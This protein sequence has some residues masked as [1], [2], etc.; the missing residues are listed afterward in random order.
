[1]VSDPVL[2]RSEEACHTHEPRD[3]FTGIT[4]PPV[5]F[6]LPSPTSREFRI[7]RRID[8]G[9]DTLVG[10][11]LLTNVVDWQAFTNDAL[12]VNPC[13]VCYFIQTLDEHG[14]PSPKT[15]V[16]CFNIA[17]RVDLPTPVLARV[18]P[19]GDLAHP[20]MKLTWF[21]PPYGVERFEVW[22][23]D[24]S[25]APDLSTNFSDYLTYSNYSV[26]S[27]SFTNKGHLTNMPFYV[28]RTPRVGPGFGYGALF[29]VPVNITLG[30]TYAF[31]VKAMAADDS[32]VLPSNAEMALWAE[33]NKVEEVPW[34]ARPLVETNGNFNVDARFLSPTNG[35]SYLDSVYY[36][37]AVLIGRADLAGREIFSANEKLIRIAGVYN[38]NDYLITNNFSDKIFP[39]ALYR[40]QVANAEFPTVSGDVVQVSPLMEEIAYGLSGGATI[41]LDPF[42]DVTSVPN[43]DDLSRTLIFFWLRDTQPQI[44]GAAYRY[45]LVRFNSVR[46]I[47]Q[48]IQTLPVTVP[49]TL[50]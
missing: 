33:T 5:I 26:S 18:V 40:Y 39:V 32:V 29:T 24:A 20:Q 4:I 7:F 8:S 13:T 41:I 17:G 42:I 19:Q 50:R 34:P 43:P 10:Q 2:M 49:C 30:R 21:C 36:G 46:E 37:N 31:F 9:P 12:P 28:F 45:L 3:P 23:G 6:W 27:L 11:G 16:L 14:N 15:N 44:S 25:G 1:M 22:V 38:P 48:I 47:D 35:T